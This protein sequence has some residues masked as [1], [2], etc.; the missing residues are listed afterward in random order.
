MNKVNWRRSLLSAWLFLSL[1]ALSGCTGSKHFQD[2]DESGVSG[3]PRFLELHRGL[4]A[5]TLHFPAGTYVLQA[6]DDNGYYYR[7]PRP[8]VEHDFSAIS[9]QHNGGLYR[10]KDGRGLRGYVYRVGS[11]T[12]VGSFG[13][14]DYTLHD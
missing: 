7:A 1:G 12:H 4:R 10:R 13:H 8:V 11:L 6:T 14:A 5:A 3:V 9:G 2:V